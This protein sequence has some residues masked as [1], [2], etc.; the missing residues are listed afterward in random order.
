MFQI[1]RNI[2]LGPFASDRLLSTFQFCGITH[3][4]NVSGSPNQLGEKEGPFTSI[5]WLPVRDG[6]TIPL[7][8]AVERLNKIHE[9]LCVSES[10]LY[11]HCNSGIY[12]SPTVL[13]LYF[14]SCG[15]DPVEAN[16]LIVSATK[17]AKPMAPNLITWQ[18][19]DAVKKHGKE[20]FQPHPRP[21]ALAAAPNEPL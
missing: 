18:L 14:V 7:D 12:R 21:S 19:V 4:V 8:D 3:I 5:A 15:I 9:F 1:T 13:W 17:K 16:E 11:I 2:W 10:N 6:E 20:T